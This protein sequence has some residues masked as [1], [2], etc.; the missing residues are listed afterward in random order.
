MYLTRMEMDIGKR[1]TMRAMVFPNLIHGA[2]ESAFPGERKRNLWRVDSLH[3]K[4][5]LMILSEE[6]PDLSEAVQQFG[7]NSLEQAWETKD[8]TQL[9]NRIQNGSQWHFRLTANPTH[10][11]LDK[12]G[13][14]RRGTVYAHI[15]VDNQKRWLKEQALKHGFLLDDNQ[16]TVVNSQWYHFKK[17]NG[18]KNMVTLLG[19][20]YE[21]ILTV[22]D[23]ECFSDM[24]CKGLGR[25]KAYGMGL[26]TVVKV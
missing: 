22:T 19:V 6:K 17:G 12:E 18:K 23:A 25:G 26:L 24:M 1:D 8:Y 13:K 5:Y 14:N 7:N 10:G 21:G 9:L 4:K 11:V 15:T 3:G 16:F 2:V 20:T